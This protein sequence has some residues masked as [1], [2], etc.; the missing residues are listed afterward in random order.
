MTTREE[1]FLRRIN[2]ISVEVPSPVTRKEKLL[3]ELAGVN[4]L[5]IELP[6]VSS[7]DD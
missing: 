5:G 7:A 6:M 4:G 2:D 1:L 3:Y